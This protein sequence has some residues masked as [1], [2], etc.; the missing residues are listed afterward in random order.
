LK[1]QEWIVE[2]RRGLECSGL[3]GKGRAGMERKGVES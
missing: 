2:E 3:D 1:W